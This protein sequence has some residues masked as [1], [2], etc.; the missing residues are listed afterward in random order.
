[1]GGGD[2]RLACAGPLIFSLTDSSLS[3]VEH[4]AAG[5]VSEAALQSYA[6]WLQPGGTLRLACE[7]VGTDVET[8]LLLCGFVEV[9]SLTVAGGTVR[10][11]SARKPT[12]DAGAAQKLSFAPPAKKAAWKLDSDDLLE[13]E[14][15]APA[16]SVWSTA[17]AAGDDDVEDENALLDSISTVHAPSELASQVAAAGDDC[18]TSKKTCKN[19]VCGRAAGEA[20][21]ASALKEKT[22]LE[23]GAAV[24]ANGKLVIDTG[25][26]SSGGAC[27]SCS[28]GDAF[29]CAGCPSKGLPAYSVGQKVVIDLE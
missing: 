8:Q 26:L 12:W 28:L 6:R 4:S 5:A 25:K 18:S 16:A 15:R 19:C 1:M 20:V 7:P 10:S 22:L 14:Y 29:R 21:E 13:A 11:V 27:G 9:A 23:S 2:T 3:A 17:A 24:K